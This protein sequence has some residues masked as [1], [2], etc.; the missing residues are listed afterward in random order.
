MDIQEKAHNYA[1]N[2]LEPNIKMLEEA[3]RINVCYDLF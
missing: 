1:L 3:Y 2:A